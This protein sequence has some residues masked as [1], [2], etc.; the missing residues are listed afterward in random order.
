M[1]DSM[2]TEEPMWWVTTDGDLDCHDLYLRHYSCHQYKDDRRLR[3]KRF[4]GPGEKIVLRTLQGDA[5]F[6]WRKFFDQCID[7]RTGLPQ[8]GIN[9]AV[10]RNESQWLSSELIRQAD[11]IADVIWPNRRHYTYVNQKAVASKNAGFC[12]KKAGWF[13]CGTTK[14]G[15]LILE[16]TPSSCNIPHRPIAPHGVAHGIE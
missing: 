13:L 15:L 7:Y 16:K 9:C 8:D 4:C 1:P 11:A 12:Y 6:V 3:D 10:F 14:G 2:K 5:M